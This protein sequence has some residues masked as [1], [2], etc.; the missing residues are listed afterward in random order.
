MKLHPSR[1]LLAKMYEPRSQDLRNMVKSLL[2]NP[3]PG[4][5]MPVTDKPDTY[6]FS[7]S[8]VW[9]QYEVDNTGM[10]TVIRAAIVNRPSFL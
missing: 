1:E 4:W 8:G 6:E 3:H 9:I 2:R 10:E 7:G 5:A